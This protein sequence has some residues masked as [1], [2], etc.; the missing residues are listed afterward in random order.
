MEIPNLFPNKLRSQ[1]CNLWWFLLQL[2]NCF[3]ASVNCTSAC[4]WGCSSTRPFSHVSVHAGPGSSQGTQD[5]KMLLNRGFSPLSWHW[6][7]GCNSSV[8]WVFNY[9]D[10][11]TF[12]YQYLSTAQLIKTQHVFKKILNGFFNLDSGFRVPVNLLKI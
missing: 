4:D 6:V 2:E 11:I 3:S 12:P 10:K 8:I 9:P 1:G 5:S 7:Y